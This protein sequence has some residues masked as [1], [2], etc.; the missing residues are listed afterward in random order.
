MV[1]LG[2]PNASNFVQ[3]SVTWQLQ[4]PSVAAAAAADDDDDGIGT[5]PS[6][7][8]FCQCDRVA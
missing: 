7:S 8:T 6:Q 2:A 5:K 3:S 4:Q 1:W